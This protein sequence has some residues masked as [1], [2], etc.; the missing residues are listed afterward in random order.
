[1]DQYVAQEKPKRIKVLDLA[2]G[3]GEATEVRSVLTLLTD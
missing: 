2:A 3:S 1:M